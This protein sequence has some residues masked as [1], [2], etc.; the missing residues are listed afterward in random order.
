MDE[1][2]NS[3]FGASALVGL[4]GV[5]DVNDL[6]SSIYEVALGSESSDLHRMQKVV[7]KFRQAYDLFVKATT[8]ICTGVEC[9]VQCL[10]P[11]NLQSMLTSPGSL[12]IPLI[13]I[14]ISVTSNNP[15]VRSNHN[16]VIL[17]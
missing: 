14:T 17:L 1:G 7:S 3:R 9:L 6:Y 15:L 16:Q 12:L 13:C 11:N 10:Q 8:D 4:T 5:K 2:E